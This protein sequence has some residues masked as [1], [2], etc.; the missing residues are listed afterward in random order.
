M[1][2]AFGD[3]EN[4][5]AQ[6]VAIANFGARPTSVEVSV[7]LADDETIVPKR[8]NVPGQAV[9]TVDTATLAPIGASY[10]VTVHA[11]DTEGPTTPIVA[12]VLTSWPPTVG[13]AASRRHSAP[14][15]ARRWVIALPD[16][17]LG[18]TAVVK[19]ANPSTE[20]ATAALLAQRAGDTRPPTSQPEL[21]IPA[22]EFGSFDVT[23]M[24]GRVLDV[25]ADHPVVVALTIVGD[26]GGSESPPCPTCSPGL[27]RSTI[28]RLADRCRDR[29]R[30]LGSDRA[31]ASVGARR[32]GRHP[33]TCTR[34]PV[35][36][37]ERLPP[38][39]GAVARRPLLV[40]GGVP[41]VRASRRRSA[42]GS[43]V[44]RGRDV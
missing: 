31:G 1:E 43:R 12:E 24:T 5:A 38:P 13:G 4:S 41:R 19:V 18:T 27:L 8:V 30:R 15:T 28:V 14:R 37:T 29:T 33:A 44:A 23:D 21:A 32:M 39:R 22:A 20:P 25:T 7:R 40:G 16:L 35:S 3:G 6:S 9:V 11:R 36:S 10:T 17:P 2:F 42:V 26:V 34:C